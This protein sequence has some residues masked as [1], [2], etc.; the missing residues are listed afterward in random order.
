MTLRRTDSLGYMLALASRLFDKRMDAALS[1]FGSAAGQYAPLVMLFEQD[2]L[3][4]AELCRRIQVEQPTMANT[5]NRMERDGLIERRADPE[6]KRKI[7]IFLTG[8][9]KQHQTK[10]LEAARQVPDD[11]LLGLSPS[12]QD[13]LMK[14]LGQVIANLPDQKT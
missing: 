1:D 2:G 11:A 13:A 5:L 12:D 4:Q 7:H 8:A 10:I 9:A 14:L 6:D 3:T